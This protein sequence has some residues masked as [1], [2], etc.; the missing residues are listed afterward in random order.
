[1]SDG[2][3][4]VNSWYG[5]PRSYWI[6]KFY[7]C[8]NSI[9]RIDGVSNDMVLLRLLESH[10]IPILLYAIEVIDVA[11]RN[12][13]R[14]LRVAYNSVFRKIFHYRWSESVTALQG[15]LQRPTWEQLVDKRRSGFVNRLLNS[16]IDSLARRLLTW[17]V[18]ICI[19]S[20]VTVF[21]LCYTSL[22]E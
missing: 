18:L 14:Q 1:M 7:R 5:F 10:C 17:F 11:D 4:G 19:Y 13:R 12:E 20:N 2:G 22:C 8:L 3:K 16:Q 6:K 15:F 9:L 21:I